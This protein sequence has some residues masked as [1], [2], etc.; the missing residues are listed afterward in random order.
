MTLKDITELVVSP[1]H[2][3]ESISYL[4]KLIIEDHHG[5]LEVFPAFKLTP[6]FHFLE[7]YLDL[8]KCCEP[9][10]CIWAMRFEAKHNF[11]VSET[12]FS[13]SPQSTK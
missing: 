2:T 3:E 6:K 4:D 9:L 1:V 5:L 8:I 13:L 10:V 7:H 12:F 11:T